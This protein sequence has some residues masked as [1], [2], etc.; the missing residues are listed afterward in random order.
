MRMY[1]Q[2]RRARSSEQGGQVYR[3]GSTDDRRYVSGREAGRGGALEFRHNLR[4]RQGERTEMLSHVHRGSEER[5]SGGARYNRGQNG[6][7]EDDQAAMNQRGVAVQTIGPDVI[8]T[9]FR[10]DR[11]DYLVVDRG[12]PRDM[13]NLAG[14]KIIVIR[15]PELVRDPEDPNNR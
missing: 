9:T 14:Q 8:S 3:R 4:P 6:P 15:D 2:V 5:G 12:D 1:E 7:S 11:Q 13:P 10:Q